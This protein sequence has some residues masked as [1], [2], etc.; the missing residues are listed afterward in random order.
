[1]FEDRAGRSEKRGDKAYLKPLTDVV[2]LALLEE[3]LVVRD[4]VHAGGR[5]RAVACTIS[6]CF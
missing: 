3:A 4:A 6:L 5:E 1:M 2:P